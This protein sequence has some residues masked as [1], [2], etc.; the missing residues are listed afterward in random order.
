MQSRSIES[1]TDLDSLRG[2]I[3]FKKKDHRNKWFR[4]YEMES[5]KIILSGTRNFLPNSSI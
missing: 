3:K 2:L 5:R 1:G 4:A